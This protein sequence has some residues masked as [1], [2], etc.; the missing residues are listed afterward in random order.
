MPN[1][2]HTPEQRDSL[3]R[4]RAE[5]ERIGYDGELYEPDY[6]YGDWFAPGTP[7]R[8]VEGAA[9]GRTPPGF[10]TA[11]FAVVASSGGESGI[12][13]IRECRAFGAPRAFEVDPRGRVFHWRVCV[14]P[15]E[16]DQQQTIRPD[17][18]KAVFNENAR[19]WSPED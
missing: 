16:G 7:E 2:A 6:K 15:E 4:V 14:S 13:R 19:D 1:T 10:D 8:T 5:L 9:F 17:Q 18:I 3:Q 11:C 12:D